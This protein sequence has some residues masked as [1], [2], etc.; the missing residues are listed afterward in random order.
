MLWLRA[1]SMVLFGVALAAMAN[2]LGVASFN[3]LSA[4]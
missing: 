3:G 4:C 2:A 1:G